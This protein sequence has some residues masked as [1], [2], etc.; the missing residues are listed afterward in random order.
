MKKVAF[1]TTSLEA[2]NGWGRYSLEIIKRLPAHGIQPVVWMLKSAPQ[3]ELGGHPVLSSLGDGADK[4]LKVALDC[5]RVGRRA[6]DCEAVHCLAEPLMPVARAMAGARPFYVTAV[7]TYALSGLTSRWGGM[8][9][10]AYRQAVAVPAISRYTAERLAADLP[11]VADK[12]HVI[13]LGVDATGLAPDAG[14]AGSARENAF[15]MVG[16]VKPR[17]GTMQAVEALARVHERFP[18]A[19]LYIAGAHDEGAYVQA[20]RERVADLGLQAHVHWLG[21][22]SESELTGLYHRVR[23]LVMPSLNAGAA[24]EGFGLVHLEANAFGVPAIGSAGCGNEDAIRDGKSG[25][26]IAQGDVD[27]LATVMARLIDPGFG[28]DALSASALAFARAMTWD[29]VAAS[30]AQLYQGPGARP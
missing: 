12:L 29:R 18:H 1:V 16:Q 7:G 24:F 14:P 13:P 28:W 10:R 26:L 4:L 17:K 2:D 25:Y 20:V 11:E 30:Y 8:Y 21:R 19:R 15:L 23:G 3:T 5:W 9:R 27:A 22:V 6:I